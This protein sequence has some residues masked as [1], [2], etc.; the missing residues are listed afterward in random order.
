MGKQ[1]SSF[2]ALEDYR[3][4]VRTWADARGRGEFRR[5]SAHLGIHTTLVSQILNHRKSLTEEQGSKLCAYMGLNSLETDY[6][7]KLIQ[8]ERAGTE[9]L[10]GV[11]R[12]HL[13]EIRKRADEI[14]SRVPEARELTEQDRAIFYSSWQH[15]LVRLLTSIDQF[16]TA[17][18]ISGYLGLS[19]SRVQE[20][21]DF[22][23][24]RGLC[25]FEKGR[26]VRS[27][28]NT[29]VES[30]SSL[31]VRH[32][33]NWRA[34][35]VDLVED[36]DSEDL[37]FTAPVSLSKKDFAKIRAALLATISELSKDISSSPA[38]RVAYLGIDW[39]KM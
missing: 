28:Q 23:C 36:A 9:Q 3:S 7:L 15:G 12:R 25:S 34:K 18:K 32:H 6:F 10:R 24:S 2:F 39:I 17:E 29:H 8:V 11:Y 22:L 35:S 37:I 16:Q 33:Q 14:K 20:I 1:T 4:Y 13:D 31:A 5:I 21:L 26:Y 30:G 19:L 38:E 27:P